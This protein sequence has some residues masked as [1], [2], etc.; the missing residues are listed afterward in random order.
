MPFD[1]SI[2]K[3]ERDKH[4]GRKLRAELP[5]ILAWAVKGCLRWQKEGL[6]EPAAVATAVAHYR[7]EMDLVADFIADSCG[8]T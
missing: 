6:G 5:G 4:L 2:P 1:V 8:S 7:Q 3:E